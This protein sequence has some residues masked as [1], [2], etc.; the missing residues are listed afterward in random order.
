MNSAIVNQ[1]SQTRVQVV[2]DEYVFTEKPIM[3]V[4][5]APSY[6][7]CIMNACEIV[8]LCTERLSSTAEV[9]V[10]KEL[11]KYELVFDHVKNTLKNVGTKTK[12]FSFSLYANVTV[13]NTTGDDTQC[14]IAIVN[15]PNDIEPKSFLNK[16]VPSNID[17]I[18]ISFNFSDNIKLRPDEEICIVASYHRGINVNRGYMTLTPL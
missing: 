2:E 15:V 9:D 13:A 4:P 8:D 7:P 1:L 17:S 18:K 12:H 5:F 14:Q 11:R 16:I 6:L 10:V 3:I